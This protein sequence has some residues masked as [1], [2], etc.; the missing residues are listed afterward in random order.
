M[1]KRRNTKKKV[2]LPQRLRELRVEKKLTLSLAAAMARLDPAV[3]SKI[4]TG[5]RKISRKVLLALAKAYKT[6]TKELLNLFYTDQ[7]VTLLSSELNPEEIL[8]NALKHY[9]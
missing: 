3:L 9:K 8:A 5:K 6:D 2:T 4:E 1:S 7:I